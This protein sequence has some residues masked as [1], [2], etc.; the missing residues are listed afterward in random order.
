MTPRDK[1]IRP[2]MAQTETLRNVHPATVAPMACRTS[3]YTR[4]AR[5]NRKMTT[6]SV[7]I[8]RIGSIESDVMPSMAKE[9]IFFSGYLLSPAN[10][11]ARS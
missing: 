1:R 2:P 9:I 3:E 5:L 8:I 4:I 11:S 10:R 7:V 6:P